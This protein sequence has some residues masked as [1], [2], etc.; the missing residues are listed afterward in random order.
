MNKSVEMI[1]GPFNAMQQWGKELLHGG[2]VALTEDERKYALWLVER[3]EESSGLLS[4]ALPVNLLGRVIDFV[5]LIL[6]LPYHSNRLGGWENY[7]AETRGL[8]VE[9]FKHLTSRQREHVEGVVHSFNEKVSF[10]WYRSYEIG[11][12]LSKRYPEERLN[13]LKKWLANPQGEPPQP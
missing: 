12:P 6:G 7:C 8:K 10:K 3:E 5:T 13:L 1:E 9:L 4:K 11:E 2:L